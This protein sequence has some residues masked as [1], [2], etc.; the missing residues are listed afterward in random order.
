MLPPGWPSNSQRGD[1]EGRPGT[2]SVF[3]KGSLNTLWAWSWASQGRGLGMELSTQTFQT[4]WVHRHQGLGWGL[5]QTFRTLWVYECQRLGWCF[6]PNT[7][8]T[9]LFPFTQLSS[10]P[11]YFLGKCA[12]MTPFLQLVEPRVL[13]MIGKSFS[14]EPNPQNMLG[15]HSSQPKPH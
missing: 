14:T 5:T 12:P 2:R 10:S 7:L 13:Y 3:S 11:I 15:K 6:H 9:F 4:L 1:W 8:S